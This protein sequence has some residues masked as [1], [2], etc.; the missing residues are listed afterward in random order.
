M[1][2]VINTKNDIVKEVIVIGANHHNT[3][4]IIR[5]LGKQ[6]LIVD[7]ILIDEELG[8]VA[9]SKYIRNCILVNSANEV[10]LHLNHRG[11]EKRIIFSCSD[12]ISSILNDNYNELIEFYHFFNCS[13]Q[14]QLTSYMNKYE[15]TIIAKECGF[16]IPKSLIVEKNNCYDFQTYP[17]IVKPLASINGGK[18]LF[19]CDNA[20]ELN[21]L[22]NKY[23]SNCPL[24]IQEKINIKYEIVILGLSVNNDIIIPGYIY[25]Y[26]EL[27]GGTTY[28]A[29][30]SI[31]T[32]DEKLIVAAR[33]L[34]QTMKYEGLFG[35]ECAFDG[36]E[37]KFI[38][39]N[40]RNDATT[41]ALSV[42]GVNLPYVYYLSKCDVTYNSLISNEIRNITSMVEFRD[43]SFVL[44]G[45]LHPY[46]WYKELKN[47]ECLY[48]YDKEDL[49]PYKTAKKQFML[50]IIKKLIKF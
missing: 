41:F 49:K 40:L 22:I 15:Q 17:C 9:D 30:Y 31:N 7:L 37:F 2:K 47:A 38:E 24:L 26:R 34:V 46:K 25:K 23:S 3:L 42:A 12:D 14:G 1:M 28:S 50:N 48:Y 44:K 32:L 5:C 29:V 4:S 36:E 10:L 20:N 33:E 35:I 16:S 19:F 45:K 11:A 18:S 39:I 21:L 27:V 8:F 13:K 6:G 43:I